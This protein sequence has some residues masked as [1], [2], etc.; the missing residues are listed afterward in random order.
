MWLTQENF[1]NVQNFSFDATS[2]FRVFLVTNTLILNALKLKSTLE[3]TFWYCFLTRRYLLQVVLVYNL[4]EFWHARDCS[5][6]NGAHTIVLLMESGVRFNDALYW[7]ILFSIPSQKNQSISCLKKMLQWTS[8][9][10]VLSWIFFSHN[11]ADW[12]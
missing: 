9:K 3:D 5:S 10:V 8:A 4:T 1:N 7:M 11:L 2:I 6:T 12:R